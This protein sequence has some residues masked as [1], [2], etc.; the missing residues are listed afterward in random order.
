[1]VFPR[2]GQDCAPVPRLGVQIDDGPDRTFCEHRMVLSLL[3]QKNEAM[4]GTKP[5]RPLASADMPTFILKV[6]QVHELYAISTPKL[7]HIERC[8]PKYAR[9]SHDEDCCNR[10]KDPSA[11]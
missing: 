1:M 2:N 3:T 10:R 8:V 4:G 5:G 7:S 6:F 11:D 9:G